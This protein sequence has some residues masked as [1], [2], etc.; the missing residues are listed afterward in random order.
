MGAGIITASSSGVNVTGVITATTFSGSGASLT[1]I[2][3]G[4]LTNS[5]VSYGGISLALGASDAT[6]AL[7]L[8]D[9]FLVYE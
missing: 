8:Q 5:T 4:A 2:P 7:Y 6:P 1:S 3:N 9:D